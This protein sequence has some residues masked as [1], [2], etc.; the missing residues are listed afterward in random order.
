MR[1][2]RQSQKLSLVGVS[3]TVVMAVHQSRCATDPAKGVPQSI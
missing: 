1:R 3:V 2:A